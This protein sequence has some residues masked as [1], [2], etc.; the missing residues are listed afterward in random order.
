MKP[1][2]HFREFLNAGNIG[3]GV[4]AQAPDDQPGMGAGGE[5]LVKKKINDK[6]RSNWY[7]TDSLAYMHHMKKKIR[8]K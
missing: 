3:G 5:D 4:P 6:V 2:L 1:T 7:S 8:K